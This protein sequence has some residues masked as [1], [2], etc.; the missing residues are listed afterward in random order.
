MFDL[1]TFELAPYCDLCCVCRSIRDDIEQ[2][3]DHVW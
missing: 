1:L 2:E 3:D